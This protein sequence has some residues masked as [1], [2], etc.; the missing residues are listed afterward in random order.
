MGRLQAEPFGSDYG[1]RDDP[2]PALDCGCDSPP[3]S[4]SES[5][6]TPGGGSLISAD[7][8]GD[9]GGAGSL[10]DVNVATPDASDE[11]GTSLISADVGGD[12]GS[13]GSLIDVNVD[14]PGT[15]GGD[16]LAGLITA[17]IGGDGGGNGSLFDLD[18]VPAE[19]EAGSL[20]TARIASGSVLD[21]T[22]DQG[23]HDAGI[24]LQVAALAGEGLLD[25][26]DLL[27]V[28]GQ[29]GSDGGLLGG[30][31]GGDDLLPAV[32]SLI[33]DLSLPEG[34]D[35]GGILDHASC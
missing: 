35:L 17:D 2:P 22:V 14:S 32:S 4:D 16:D 24:G 8:G 33:G 34:L 18:I 1:D 30:I 12:G 11:G 26:T 23:E 21:A 7:V 3:P 29:L 9:G 15:P 25:V 13:T 5:E 31:V 27:D 20:L 10:V 6:G 28:P 19:G